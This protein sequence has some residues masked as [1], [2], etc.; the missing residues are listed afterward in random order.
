MIQATKYNTRFATTI[1]EP[2]GVEYRIA[3]RIPTSEQ[4]T[5][6]IVAATTTPLKFLHNCI[7]VMD[8][9]II[10]ADTNSD[11]TRFMAS[12]MMIAVMIATIA[13]ERFT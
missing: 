12:T 3:H 1:V 10:K 5:D 7:A 2:T 13:L 11:P 6:N 4:T 9:K 8:G